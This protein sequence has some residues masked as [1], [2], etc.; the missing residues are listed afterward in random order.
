MP[1]IEREGRTGTVTVSI[2]GPP[3]AEGWTDP[4]LKPGV[5]NDRQNWNPTQP[6]DPA[7]MGSYD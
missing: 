6:A 3:L 7:V 5:P 4:G 2:Y 1:G